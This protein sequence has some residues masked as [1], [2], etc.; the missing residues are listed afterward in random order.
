MIVSCFGTLKSFFKLVICI[1]D[2]VPCLIMGFFLIL[3][4]WIL[5]ILGSNALLSTEYIRSGRNETDTYL[6]S[7]VSAAFLCVLSVAAGSLFRLLIGCA[8]NYE[9]NVRFCCFVYW[10]R[11]LILE[12]LSFHFDYDVSNSTCLAFSWW[13]LAIFY[14]RVWRD[15]KS[16]TRFKLQKSILQLCI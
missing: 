10:F 14:S 12:L 1:V 5:E 9:R 16:C 2:A 15:Q 8:P 3:K 4:K 11:F 13:I 6:C 7:E